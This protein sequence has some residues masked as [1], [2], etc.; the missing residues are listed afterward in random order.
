MKIFSSNPDC[1]IFIAI[2]IA[3]E[4]PI[5]IDRDPVFM[6]KPDPDFSGKTGPRF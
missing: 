5:R 2:R 3:I 1:K 6:F 4:N